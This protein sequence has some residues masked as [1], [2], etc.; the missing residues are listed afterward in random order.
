MR[1]DARTFALA[2]AATLA[3]S[4]TDVAPEDFDPVPG[5]PA[6]I[7]TDASLYTLAK[8][9][10]GYDAEAQAVYT[11]ATGRTI[12]YGRCAT[13]SDGPMF[14]VRRTGPDS[15]APNCTTASSRPRRDI[16]P[17]GSSSPRTKDAR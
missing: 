2:V 12:Y 4:A 5:A 15:T 17:G 11:N 3:C 6:P 16:F 8:V 7:A 1:N 10:G 14:L 13:E 9:P